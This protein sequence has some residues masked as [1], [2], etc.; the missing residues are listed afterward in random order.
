MASSSTSA[1]EIMTEN[2]RALLIEATY[3]V[4]QALT[5]ADNRARQRLDDLVTKV[6]SEAEPAPHVAV[7]KGAGLSEAAVKAANA[8]N[9]FHAW[10]TAQNADEAREAFVRPGVITPDNPSPSIF[11][12]R[13][14]FLEAQ[15]A[16][17]RELV[18]CAHH[19]AWKELNRVLG[20]G[21]DFSAKEVDAWHKS[22]SHQT[23]WGGISKT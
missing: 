6:R 9:A 5:L 18:R 16:K 14:K 19:E 17:L 12:M 20:L 1:E 21:G 4:R 7:A 10:A 22:A 3:R 2:E 13:I 11:E 23:L 8:P 15:N